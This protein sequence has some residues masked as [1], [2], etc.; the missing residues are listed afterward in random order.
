MRPAKA[1]LTGKFTAI[2]AYLRK[3][4]KSQINNQIF[5]LKQ[6]QKE[7]TEPQISRRKETINI[8]AE[9]NET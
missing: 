5:H 1:V 9:I 2:Q 8:R 7:Q 3:Q 4:E 6:L